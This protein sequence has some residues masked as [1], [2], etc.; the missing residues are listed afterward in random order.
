MN[1]MAIH[2]A[3]EAI[4]ACMVEAAKVVSRDTKLNMAAGS[5]VIKAAAGFGNVRT[6]FMIKTSGSAAAKGRMLALLIAVDV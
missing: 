3:A 6:R 1:I 5:M 4:T 2:A